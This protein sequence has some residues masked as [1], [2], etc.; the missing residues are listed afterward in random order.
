ML[1]SDG[2][3]VLA[4]GTLSRRKLLAG[5]AA[6]TAAAWVAPSVVGMAARA[7]ASSDPPGNGDPP[8]DTGDPQE[9][10]DPQT[11]QGGTNS[12]NTDPPNGDGEGTHHAVL[13][14]SGGGQNGT[15]ASFRLERVVVL[16][17]EPSGSPP[18]AI[19]FAWDGLKG[20]WFASA[21]DQDDKQVLGVRQLGSWKKLEP[22]LWCSGNAK[23]C[24]VRLRQHRVQKQTG[25]TI[26]AGYIVRDSPSG[27]PLVH[28]R[29]AASVA[30]DG[31]WA[32]FD[33]A[34]LR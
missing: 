12:T 14:G 11:E 24:T 7:A 5:L 18:A 33:S 21:P 10:N 17:D 6:G 25:V 20:K 9:G 30:S 13:A 32:H 29:F 31:N 34:V 1:P 19:A 16:C 23:S 3:S 22:L 4:R 2:G 27:A 26:E 15:T 8:A 28:P